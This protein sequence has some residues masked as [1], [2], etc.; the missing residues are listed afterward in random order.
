MSSFATANIAEV[1]DQ[2]TTDEAILLIAGV[3]LWYTHPIPRLEIPS[4]KMTNGPNGEVD[5]QLYK[6]CNSIGAN[7]QVS[8][9]PISS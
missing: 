3:G 8:L 5:G 6:I 7:R 2:L 4:I 1:V 9:A